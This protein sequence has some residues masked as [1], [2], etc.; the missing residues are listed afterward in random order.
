MQGLL[1]D[2]L[3]ADE[4]GF[5]GWASP[6]PRENLSSILIRQTPRSTRVTFVF[7]GTLMKH[8]LRPFAAIALAML[9]AACSSPNYSSWT[10]I[11]TQKQ[12]QAKQLKTVKVTEDSFGCIRDMTPVRGFY[13][14]NLLGDVADTLAAAN[15]PNG[16][17]WPPGSVVQRIPSEAMVKHHKGYS[18]ATND[19]EFY[20]LDVRRKSTRIAER[21]FTNV[22]NEFGGNC[23]TCHSTAEPRWDMI[24]EQSHGC[25]PNPITHLMAVA[26]QNS[27]PRCPKVSLPPNQQAALRELA[28][29]LEVDSGPSASR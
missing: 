1:L 14:D 24:C 6:D 3:C 22:I 27:D 13:V 4:A 17:P 5:T 25:N 23:L 15:K 9:A 16:G 19:W 8:A 26:I 21:G 28:A 12:A 20:V 11:N 18:P 7:T 29:L 10:R 2:L